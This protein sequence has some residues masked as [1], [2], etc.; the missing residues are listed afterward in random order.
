MMDTKIDEQ[1]ENRLYTFFSKIIDS[2]KVVMIKQEDVV[3][4][5][6]WDFWECEL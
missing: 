2:N 6:I 3:Y 1:L 5:N 4:K